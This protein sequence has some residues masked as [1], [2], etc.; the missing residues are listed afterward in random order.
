MST[1]FI[2]TFAAHF[3]LRTP[4]RLAGSSSLDI[5][6]VFEILNPNHSTCCF[7][8]RPSLDD[9]PLDLKSDTRS[10]QAA[11]CLLA[12][13]ARCSKI[14]RETSVALGYNP[15]GEYHC[16][17]SA[18]WG[19]ESFVSNMTLYYIDMVLC[20]LNLQSFINGRL[21]L[22]DEFPISPLNCHLR[23]SHRCGIMKH[24]TERLKFLQ[25]T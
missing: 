13:S 11:A 8:S 1:S 22:R 18:C 7:R 12:R 23:R 2:I 15:R 20:D 4:G 6:R 3:K 9:F 17:F 24:I 10:G 19:R 14:S 5:C 16:L 25:T 21:Q